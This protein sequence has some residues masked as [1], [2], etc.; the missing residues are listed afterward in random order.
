MLPW[1][2][3]VGTGQLSWRGHLYLA[4]LRLGMLLV[5]TAVAQAHLSKIFLELFLIVLFVEALLVIIFLGLVIFLGLI[6][7]LGLLGVFC[8]GGRP[9]SGP[10]ESLGPADSSWRHS[11]WLPELMDSMGKAATAAVLALASVPEPV[12]EQSL[13][14]LV[15]KSSPHVSIRAFL[16]RR[17]SGC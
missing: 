9:G 12:A 13:V 16:G 6:I 11:S 17:V 3:T 5:S 15:I 2:S 4:V 14:F 8:W 10:L 1:N 7:F